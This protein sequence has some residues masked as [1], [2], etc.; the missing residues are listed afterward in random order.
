[1]ANKI[2]KLSAL[3]LVFIML[4][5][6]VQVFADEHILIAPGI[7]EFNITIKITGV[8]QAYAGA[9]IDIVIDN[10]SSID[11]KRGAGGAP[12]MAYASGTVCYLSEPRRSGDQISYLLGFGSNDAQN[13]FNGDLDICTITFT[14]TGDATSTISIQNIKLLRYAGIVN[15]LPKFEREAIGLETVYTVD[16]YNGPIISAAELKLSTDKDYVYTGQYFNVAAE[17]D[18]AVNSNAASLAFTYDADIFEYCGF[19]AASGL[20]DFKIDSGMAG[21]VAVILGGLSGYG[22]SDLGSLLFYVKDGA[23][24]QAGDKTIRAGAEYVNLQ[25]GEKT[26]LSASATLAINAIAGIPGDTNGDGVVNLIDLSNMI[27]W[28]GVKAGDALWS[29]VKYFDFNNNGEIDI[30]DIAYVASIIS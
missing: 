25:D 15:G 14:Y 30:S 24:V 2:L 28:F 29:T 11:I 10:G 21:K 23:D 6:T 4:F 18:P 1:M 26:M 5:C 22:I 3:V 27:D 12:A 9:D 17:F 7:S 16:R 19:T 8:T 13:R 20:T